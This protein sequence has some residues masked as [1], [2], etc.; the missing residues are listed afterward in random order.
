MVSGLDIFLLSSISDWLK[1][2]L[3]FGCCYSEAVPSPEGGGMD[4]SYWRIRAMVLSCLSTFPKRWSIMHKHCTRKLADTILIHIYID[5]FLA[6]SFYF[7]CPCF[8][9]A[10]T[11][12]Q[13]SSACNILWYILFY[14][15]TFSW[16]LIHIWLRKKCDLDINQ[17]APSIFH[18][19]H[20][21]KLCCRSVIPHTSTPSAC[22]SPKLHRPD[23]SNS[24]YANRLASV[25]SI[26]AN[27]WPH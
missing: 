17:L 6:F 22:A 1:V 19:R 18:P 24:I 25:V 3:T 23:R 13:F 2:I 9:I 11:G 8:C 21:L 12:L 15:A 4:L 14:F 5:E 10:K 26:Y 27:C 20:T 16:K 7:P